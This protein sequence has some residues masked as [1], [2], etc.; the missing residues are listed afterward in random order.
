LATTLMSLALPA[1]NM[2]ESD[3]QES[4][5]VDKMVEGRWKQEEQESTT[6]SVGLP[7]ERA[8]GLRDRVL[9]KWS[10]TSGDPSSIANTAETSS[11]MTGKKRKDLC[12]D[13]SGI[14]DGPVDGSDAAAS[15]FTTR[16]T[17]DLLQE[18]AE[19][20]EFAAKVDQKEQEEFDEM[21]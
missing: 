1:L 17:G 19:L 12:E 13:N 9:D 14:E 2:I 5:E 18:V 4:R 10:N 6:R 7:E 3:E 15:D 20:L 11:V 16:M 8:R 21:N